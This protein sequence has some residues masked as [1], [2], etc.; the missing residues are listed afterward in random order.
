MSEQKYK[1]QYNTNAND[2]CIHCIYFPSMQGLKMSMMT[3]GNRLK[4]YK[5]EDWCRDAKFSSCFYWQGL[6]VPAFGGEYDGEGY[7]YNLY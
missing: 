6:A 4:K 1:Y 3:N 7:P 5:V 2:P